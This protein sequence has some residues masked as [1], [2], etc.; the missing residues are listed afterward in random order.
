MPRHATPCHA[1]PRHAWHGI[2]LH[3]ITLHYI[4]LHCIT[5]QYIHI[6]IWYVIIL[7]HYTISLYF[8]IYIIVY[9]T[10]ISPYIYIYIHHYIIIKRLPRLLALFSR[11]IPLNKTNFVNKKSTMINYAGWW[12]LEHLDDFSHHI[13][14]FIIP[15]DELICF[16]G[17]GQPPTRIPTFRIQSVVAV[18]MAANHSDKEMK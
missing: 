4:A 8:I 18:P 2:T 10:Y 15:T 9:I 7:Y 3:I 16:R 1:M 6:Y 13:G 17:V 14:N 5:L 12:W 11:S